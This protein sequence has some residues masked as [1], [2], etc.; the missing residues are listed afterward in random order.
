VNNK[1]ETSL[2]KDNLPKRE[3]DELFQIHNS[4]PL[5]FLALVEDS[6]QKYMANMARL[7]LLKEQARKKKE[8]L[9]PKI[10]ATRRA[11][12]KSMRT[13]A[14]G[15][16][17]AAQFKNR[18]LYV[19]LGCG[20]MLNLEDEWMLT[21][22]DNQKL[23]AESW[24]EETHWFEG[25]V[26]QIRLN[27]KRKKVFA[28]TYNTPKTSVHEYD[29]IRV[30]SC[31]KSY[32]DLQ[33][34]E[35]K[36]RALKAQSLHKRGADSSDS[37]FDDGL[38]DDDVEHK[39]AALPLGTKLRHG[40]SVQN[41]SSQPRQLHHS[42][43]VIQIRKLPT[44][45]FEYCCSFATTKPA[46]CWFNEQTT[47]A[48][49]TNHVSHQDKM[50]QAEGDTGR[51]ACKGSNQRQT[52]QEACQ[53]VVRPKVVDT[54]LSTSKQD[55]AATVAPDITIA[56]GTALCKHVGTV[57]ALGEILGIHYT[58]HVDGTK[59][60]VYDCIFKTQPP[61]VELKVSAF[62][63]RQYVTNVQ[64]QNGDVDKAAALLKIQKTAATPL[65]QP[66]DLETADKKKLDEEEAATLLRQ[67]PE[68]AAADKKKLDEEEAATLI[69]QQTEAAAADKKKLDE[70]EAA[71]LNRQQTEAAAAEKKKLDEEE[72]ATL[73]RQQREAAAADKKKLDEEESATLLR[74][75]R[76]AAAADKKKLDEE[77]AAAKKKQDDEE[78]ATLLRQ[79]TEAAAADKKKQDEEEAA[80]LIRQQTEA[81][82]ADKKKLDEEEAA[83]LIRQQTEAAAA[84]K[85]K[86][87]E[88]EAATLIRQQT[89]AAAADKKK[90][91]EEEAATL[92]R[93]QTEVEAATT[94]YRHAHLIPLL[95]GGKLDDNHCMVLYDA[96]VRYFGIDKDTEVICPDDARYDVFIRVHTFEPYAEHSLK[97]FIALM[98][99]VCEPHDPSLAS[100]TQDG[101]TSRY[102]PSTPL[103]AGDYT[104]LQEK[105]A[106]Y[107]GFEKDGEVI[108]PGEDHYD[109]FM[110]I[111]T[112][113]IDKN[114]INDF[115][116]LMDIVCEGNVDNGQCDIMEKDATSGF[117]CPRCG[118]V[119]DPAAPECVKC[120]YCIRHLPD[121]NS[122]S[123]TCGHFAASTSVETSLSNTYLSQKGA[124]ILDQLSAASK[125]R[126]KG[127]IENP[128]NTL[129]GERSGQ[130]TKKKKKKKVLVRCDEVQ[131]SNE[132]IQVA[133]GKPAT[134]STK[135]LKK[136]KVIDNDPTVEIQAAAGRDRAV[137]ITHEAVTSKKK[138]KKRRVALGESDELASSHVDNDKDTSLPH[139][140]GITLDKKRK[141]K[142]CV[143][144]QKAFLTQVIP[145]EQLAN[146]KGHPSCVYIALSCAVLSRHVLSC[147]GLSFLVL[148][149]LVL[150]WADIAKRPTVMGGHCERNSKTLRGTEARH[151]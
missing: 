107:F 57:K 35:K 117:G 92:L 94:S 1:D 129:D 23:L 45:E 150:S 134:E 24:A 89:E 88:E 9:N 53:V 141:K 100:N 99:V 132:G 62:Q 120:A 59:T 19:H 18:E 113:D 149:C 148:S 80:T 41:S 4:N 15:S 97:E 55:D 61:T 69:R 105:M 93:Q 64:P 147:L 30:K 54:H 127:G 50:L 118:D 83:T 32:H 128:R 65:R 51:V 140:S 114:D 46:A 5:K 3:L 137:D 144:N 14:L 22:A 66:T 68:A 38:S 106:R 48:M 21:N 27:Q 44:G 98:D 102:V 87:D 104:A 70:E 130:K 95:P 90:L 133:G 71:T 84:D 116:E 143:E 8:A 145:M 33:L 125:K 109:L 40:V 67:Q 115:N 123:A 111:R 49:A 63:V 126:K 74:E 31:M 135:K 76:E 78:A 103:D 86:Q 108:L 17:V 85:K 119:N 146:A 75:Q 96:M 122:M 25:E 29:T 112:F 52:V 60:V 91:D 121:T 139:Y 131:E 142:Q 13:I 28:C 151:F 2:C 73:L 26:T 10:P 12:S 101:T 43:E 79:Q 72:A 138:K 77:E 124:Y 136:K 11:T 42:G 58:T 82:A 81:A 39:G 37:E 16:N 110:R 34:Y 36:Q 6:E 47:V 56:K 7:Q 20:E